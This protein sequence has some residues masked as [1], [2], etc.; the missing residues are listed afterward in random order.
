MKIWHLN[1]G[2]LYPLFPRGTQ[3]ILYCLLV[4]TNDGLL[5][6][7]T[8]FGIQD[9]EQPTRFI[10]LFIA[11]LGMPRSLEET[12][13]FQVEKLGYARDDVK[14]IVL[15]HLHCDHAGGLRD[16]PKAKVH[17]HAREY[18]AIQSPKGFKERFYEPDQWAHGPD[19]VIHETEETADWFSFPNLRIS[20]NLTPDVRLIPL[21][22]HTRGHCGVAIE[23]PGGWLL[24][25]GDATW[26]FYCENDPLPP[27]KPL[28][29]YVM[30]PPRWLEKNLVGEHTPRLRKLHEEHYPEIQL[31]CSN[32]SISY[33]R[34]SQ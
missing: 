5:L 28:P 29:D 2:T 30:S 33:S 32:D 15:T 8:G 13:A 10:K 17:V 22:G 21:H 12:A 14:H 9:Y 11:S 6:V 3:S 4:E 16:F 25:C 34:F 18:G 19:W 31:I 7:D 20:E 1:C 23:T 27:F 24:H 26:P